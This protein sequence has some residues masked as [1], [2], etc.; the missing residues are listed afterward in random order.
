[1]GD[2]ESLGLAE[3]GL[4]AGAKGADGGT[5]SPAPKTEPRYYNERGLG[6]GFRPEENGKD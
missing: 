2:S 1:M 3:E 4:N 6:S 5:A